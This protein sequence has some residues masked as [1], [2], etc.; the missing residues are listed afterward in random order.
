[1]VTTVTEDANNRELLTVLSL[2]FLPRLCDDTGRLTC[3][4]RKKKE[5]KTK[6]KHNSTD[7]D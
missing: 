6:E 1:V 4:K 7:R 5:K 2:R 3:Y